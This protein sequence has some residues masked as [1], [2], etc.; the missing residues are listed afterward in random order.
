MA[1]IINNPSG[2][3]GSVSSL[4]NGASINNVSHIYQ[5]TKPTTR[6]DG[7]ALVIGDKWYDTSADMKEAM[8]NGLNWVGRY[9]IVT[10]T[11]GSVSVTSITQ[12]VITPPF[13][14]PNL[15]IEKVGI[16]TRR[17]PGTYDGLNNWVIS[18]ATT[19]NGSNA[20]PITPDISFTLAENIAA[21]GSFLTYYAAV[22]PNQTLNVFNGVRSIHLSFTKN[23]APP[24]IS[25]F[26]WWMRIRE[27]Y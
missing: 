1:I 18:L 24:N 22:S 13:N 21:L 9:F 15:L 7:S 16:N 26:G 25:D 8:W 27:I 5:S 2:N 23:G 19:S 4:P 20:L 11:R 17:G 3:S 12:F 10:S 6:P 14:T